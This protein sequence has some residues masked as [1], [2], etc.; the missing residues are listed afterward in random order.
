MSV[1]KSKLGQKKL[2]QTLCPE[3]ITICNCQK[4][5]CVVTAATPKLAERPQKNLATQYERQESDFLC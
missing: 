2:A 5:T 4:T 3:T 1:Q